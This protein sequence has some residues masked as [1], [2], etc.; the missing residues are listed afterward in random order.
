MKQGVRPCPKTPT[1][2]H[3]NLALLQSRTNSGLTNICIPLC[4]L[5]EEAATSGRRGFS[6]ILNH[7]TCLLSKWQSELVFSKCGHYY[8]TTIF[9]KSLGTKLVMSRVSKLRYVCL[10]EKV[11]CFFTGKKRVSSNPCPHMGGLLCFA[12]VS[13]STLEQN[14]PMLWRNSSFYTI[15]NPQRRGREL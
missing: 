14:T 1:V 11:S 4:W 3:L 5:C 2:Q 7:H 9:K 6:N 10:K 8:I 13:V 15:P 12:K